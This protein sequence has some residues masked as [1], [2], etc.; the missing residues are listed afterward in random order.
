MVPS[1]SGRGD[2]RAPA[3]HPIPERAKPAVAEHSN[4]D[5]HSSLSYRDAGVDIEAGNAL[6]ERIKPMA[7]ATFRPGVVTGLGGFGALFELPW[8]RY[9]HP[10]LVSGTDGVGTKLKLALELGRHSTVGID[11]VGNV[12]QRRPGGGGGA[13]V[14]PRLLRHRAAGRGGG[15][16]VIA[17]IATGCELPAAR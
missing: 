10:V 2:S 13:A 8:E 6:V 17:G 1:L 7:A 4:P 9:R 11:L 16:R 14:L 5:S 15:Q 3:D 12:C